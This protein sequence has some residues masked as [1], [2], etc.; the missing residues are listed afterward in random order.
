MIELVRSVL[1]G[2]SECWLVS[3]NENLNAQGT[4]MKRTLL[5][6]L[7]A[8]SAVASQGGTALAQ[9]AEDQAAEVMISTTTTSLIPVTTT[10]FVLRW[11]TV[12]KA[13]ERQERIKR[14]ESIV[15]IEH[16]LEHNMNDVRFDFALG[17]GDSVHELVAIVNGGWEGVTLPAATTR[18]KDWRGVLAMTDRRER[19]TSLYDMLALEISVARERGGTR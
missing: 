3:P 6:L 16:Y 4:P 7:T 11:R 15:L 13:N 14:L 5:I 17:G 2:E 8:F 10:Y 1:W 12:A 9:S 19:A 18:G